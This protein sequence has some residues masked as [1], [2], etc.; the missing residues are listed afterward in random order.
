[1]KVGVR[2]MIVSLAAM[3]F[4]GE[5]NAQAQTQ[6]QVRVTRDRATIWNRDASI[7]AALVPKG[8]VLDVL[9]QEGDWYIVTVPTQS[10]G[11]G[12]SGRIAVSQVEPLPGGA[13]PPIRRPAP[14]AGNQP[15]SNRAPAKQETSI[16]GFGHVGYGTWLASETFRAV[17]GESRLLMFGGGGQVRSGNVF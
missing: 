1:M 6:A 12:E 9:A 3:L 17:L 11:K 16:S 15:P 5:S 4:V 14:S 7:I 8:T 13:A 2:L 10:G